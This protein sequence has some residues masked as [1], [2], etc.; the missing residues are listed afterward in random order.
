MI[1]SEDLSVLCP[2]LTTAQN[3]S[4][5]PL[6]RHYTLAQRELWLRTHHVT[7]IMLNSIQPSEQL[8]GRRAVAILPILWMGKLRN[9]KVHHFPNGTQLIK[10]HT[11]NPRV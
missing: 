1:F 8:S 11:R 4:F 2:V 10:V 6:L 9:R 3:S 7:H 5:V